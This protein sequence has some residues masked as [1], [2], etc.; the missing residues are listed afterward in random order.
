V[1]GFSCLI[2]YKKA[3]PSFA[4]GS[5]AG[6]SIILL[7]LVQNLATIKFG[8]MVLPCNKDQG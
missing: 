6:R 2:S 4:L 1:T 8:L 5:V 7:S 3:Y